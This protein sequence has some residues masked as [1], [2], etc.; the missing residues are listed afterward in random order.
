GLGRTGS[1]PGGRRGRRGRRNRSVEPRGVGGPVV[2]LQG[3][4]RDVGAL[5][6]LGDARAGGDGDGGVVQYQGELAG[7]VAL[8][9]DVAVPGRVGGGDQAE[10][11]GG[12]PL[13]VHV[14]QGGALLVQSPLHGL[15]EQLAQLGLAGD[16]GRSGRVG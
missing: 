6:L 7:G 8:G 10:R 1:G 5:Q 13:P 12:Q 4:Q 14:G 3:L 2:L 15:A 11:G 9:R 16:L